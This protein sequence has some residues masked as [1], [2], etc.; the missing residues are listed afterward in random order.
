[1]NRLSKVLLNVGV[2]FALATTVLAANA[3]TYNNNI[4]TK[5]GAIGQ[6]GVNPDGSFVTPATSA[7]QTSG[8]SS[9][10]T[11]GTNTG[12]TA[13]NTTTANGYLSTMAGSLTVPVTDT[14]KGGTVTLGNTYQTA[15]ASNSSRKGCLIQNPTTATEVLNVEVGTSTHPYTLAPGMTFACMVG[16]GRVIT[17]DI[18][19]TAATTS[20]AFSGGEQQ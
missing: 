8:N 2:I 14:D 11:I 7:L 17:Q 9:L 12:T 3:P 18:K 4:G 13:T 20:H 5:T 19:V 15:I 1:M 6:I 16:G 10:T